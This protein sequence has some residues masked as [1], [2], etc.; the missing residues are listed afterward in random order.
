MKLLFWEETS[1]LKQH[2]AGPAKTTLNFTKLTELQNQSSFRA[3]VLSDIFVVID[4]FKRF[5][6]KWH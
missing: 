6:D 5:R 3:Y 1:D 2:P 4:L